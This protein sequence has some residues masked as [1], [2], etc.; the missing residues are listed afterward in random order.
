MSMM[1]DITDS[2]DCDNPYFFERLTK[3]VDVRSNSIKK[4]FDYLD[5][6]NVCQHRIEINADFNLLSPL[7]DLALDLLG[8][9]HLTGWHATRLIDPDEV[10]RRGLRAYA[11]Q[12]TRS[13]LMALFLDIGMPLGEAD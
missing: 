4:A 7:V 2:I 10:R 8:G 13:R 9:K 11:P 12:E 5:S 6:S 3:E 1:L